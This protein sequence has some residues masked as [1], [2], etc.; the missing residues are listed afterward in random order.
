MGSATPRDALSPPMELG[1][2]RRRRGEGGGR[3]KEDGGNRLEAGQWGETSD[4]DRRGERTRPT[5]RSGGLCLLHG[6][7]APHS[8][9]HSLAPL[10]RVDFTPRASS[11]GKAPHHLE[12][13]LTMSTWPQTIRLRFRVKVPTKSTRAGRKLGGPVSTRHWGLRRGRE[14]GMSHLD[15]ARGIRGQNAGARENKGWGWG[16]TLLTRS[17]CHVG[18]WLGDSASG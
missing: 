10:P 11:K 3:G 17:L 12:G 7:S 13:P 8:F 6:P 2:G 16:G 15:R 4:G 5:A 9:P 18:G 14:K 1:E